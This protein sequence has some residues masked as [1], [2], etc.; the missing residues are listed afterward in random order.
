MA[1]FPRWIEDPTVDSIAMCVGYMEWVRKERKKGRDP[2][3]LP[4]KRHYPYIFVI[5]GVTKNAS[6]IDL[7]W[8]KCT[9]INCERCR[10]GRNGYTFRWYSKKWEKTYMQH[11]REGTWAP[12]GP[13][14]GY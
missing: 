1:H 13:V 3:L 7:P 12:G 5:E 10:L 6:G 8:S 14:K 2:I 11:K 9:T 4:E